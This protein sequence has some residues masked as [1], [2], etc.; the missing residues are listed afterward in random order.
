MRTRNQWTRWSLLGVALI[1]GS[2]LAACNMPTG[3]IRISDEGIALE[4]DE[5]DT[6]TDEEET[7]DEEG[8]KPGEEGEGEAT[9]TE[10]GKPEE[11]SDE[12]E[13]EAS[14]DVDRTTS[15]GSIGCD[16]TRDGSVAQGE[17]SEWS[18]SGSAGDVV[19]I[20]LTGLG[21]FD[22]Y[23]ELL[24]PSGSEETN[25]DDTGPGRN[26]LIA[27]HTLA[28]TGTYTIIARGY[29]HRSGDYLLSL[30]CGDD[31]QPQT[32][33]SLRVVNNSGSRICT[34]NISPTDD[35][36]WTGAETVSIANGSSYTFSNLTPAEYDLRA[37]DCS[38]NTLA[39]NM[40]VDISGTYTWTVTGAPV[41]PPPPPTASLRVVNN[42]GS[43]ICTVNISPTD[44]P[45]WTG[46]ETV[47]IANG[48]SYTF[49]NITP[50]EYDL[51]ARDCS[52]N[53]LATNMDVDISGTYTWTVAG[54]ALPTASLTVVNNSGTTICTVNVSPTTDGTWT[55]A[56]SVSISNGSSY[57]FSNIT[58]G[59][60]DLRARDCSSNTLDT[61][62][63]VSLTGS[64]T[65]TVTGAPPSLPTASLT[66]VNNSGTT[67]CAV[68]ISPTT[69]STWTGA[70]SV[71][72]S[73]GSSLTITDIPIGDY[74]L[75]AQDCSSSTLDTNFGVSLTG[76]YTWNVP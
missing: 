6:G 63:G 76:T 26:A 52:N 38:N 57:T 24:N 31:D 4:G 34:V 73:N 69:D 53:T 29:N 64:Y 18:F 10:G 58:L 67:I 72:I 71:S 46:A 65:W 55:G 49:S 45:T 32:T 9:D 59:D 60:Y 54:Q 28:R 11:G 51:R 16:L 3:G 48:S 35:P 37:R 5:G 43:T 15:H 7:T 17:E 21:G 56:Q 13:A 44:D 36:T 20:T 23:L 2:L 75:R 41:P 19:T 40:D 25:D 66:V 1:L 8:G 50:A 30:G 62:M 70:Q 33:A 47:S 22:T 27:G 74:D 42:S 68:N 14:D 61:S 39:T 12:A